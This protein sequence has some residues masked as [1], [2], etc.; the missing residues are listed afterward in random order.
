M[1]DNSSVSWVYYLPGTTGWGP[2]FGERP[3]ALWVLPNPVILTSGTSFGLRTNAFGFIISWATN[4]PVV[5]EACTDPGSPIW[6]PL[7]T[8]TLT[9]G[10]SYFSDS[11]WANYPAR[12]YRLRSP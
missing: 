10:W 9:D 5:V 6:S 4:V 12:F 8:N 7:S 1:F 3:T 11:Q 2:T